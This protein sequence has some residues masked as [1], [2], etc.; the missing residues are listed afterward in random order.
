LQTRTATSRKRSPAGLPDKHRLYEEAVQN[1]AAEIHFMNRIY[2]Q[3]RGRMPRILREDF[4]G[5]AAVACRWVQEGK[6]RFA[7]GIDLDIDTLRWGL[8]HNVAPLGEAASRVELHHG[9]VLQR[10]AFRA[11]VTAALNFSYFI[12]KERASMLR[13]AKSVHHG[14]EKDGL[15]V[16]DLF[17][18][19]EA[20]I[21][22][23][24][25]TNLGKFTYIWDQARFNPVT[26]EI[27]CHIHFKLRDGRIM[28]RAFTYDWRLW[29]PREMTEILEEAG[30]GRTE[31]YWEGT[32]SKTKEGN[33]IYRRTKCGDDSAGWVAYVV[34]LK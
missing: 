15:F 12:F 9:D 29:T 7:Y 21:L 14:L 28:R 17:G 8:K 1:P 27:L 13:Y 6:E 2:S 11:D 20:Q 22:Q 34:G 19:P 10:Y 33:G 5:T 26:S 24:E 32:D 3:F 31:V 25:H 18:G 4:C 16:L 30:F 23:E